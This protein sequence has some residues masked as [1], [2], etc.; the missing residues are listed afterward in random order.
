MFAYIIENDIHE[1][2]HEQYVKFLEHAIH[3]DSTNQT[4]I[5]ELVRFCNSKSGD[6]LNRTKAHVDCMKAVAVC[7]CV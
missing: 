4:E 6:E 5:I 2:F 7:V 3:E 1:K